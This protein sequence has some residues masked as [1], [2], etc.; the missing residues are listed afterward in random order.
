[1]AG[2]R[3]A[4]PSAWF[5]LDEPTPD[6]YTLGSTVYLSR[7]AIEGKHLSGIMAHELGHI[8]HKDGDLTRLL[9]LNN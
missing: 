9:Q 4:A 2:G 7:A 3:V 5:V 8:A 1:M 6:A